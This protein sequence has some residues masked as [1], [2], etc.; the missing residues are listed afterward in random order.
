MGA[1]TLLAGNACFSKISRRA[2]CV[3]PMQGIPCTS[4]RSAVFCEDQPRA[5]R[6]SFTLFAKTAPV[7]RACAERIMDRGFRS[8][9]RTLTQ[10]KG[11]R[12]AQRTQMG[13]KKPGGLTDPNGLGETT[14]FH[15]LLLH[16]S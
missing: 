4:A 16:D 6:R 7:R 5:A 15:S 11:A 2:S 14:W 13:S 8:L 10:S 9:K 3:G 1:Q 12:W